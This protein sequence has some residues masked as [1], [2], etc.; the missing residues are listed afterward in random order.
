M[1]PCQDRIVFVK[2]EFTPLEFET[3]AHQFDT[4]PKSLLEFTPLEF[5]TFTTASQ[6]RK[7]QALEFTPLEFETDSF[8]QGFQ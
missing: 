8:S 2:L 3:L 7:A 1:P 4:E 5:E 6:K